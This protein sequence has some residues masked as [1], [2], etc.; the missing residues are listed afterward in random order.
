M[1]ND[2]TLRLDFGVAKS[3]VVEIETLHA[4]SVQSREAHITRAA[5]S[6]QLENGKFTALVSRA[7]G[8]RLTVG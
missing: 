2:L 4:P 3:G 5:K 1:E 8:L 7:S 6:G